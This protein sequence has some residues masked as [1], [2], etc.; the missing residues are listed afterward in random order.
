M[1][2]ALLPPLTEAERPRI[3]R[4]I[5]IV[6]GLSLGQSAFYAIVQLLDRL[7]RVEKLSAQ[8]AT[9]NQTQNAR[10]WLDVIYQLAGYFFAL[11]PVLLALYLLGRGATRLLGV[12]LRGRNTALRDLGW[13]VLLAAVI[14]IPGLGLYFLG[15]ALNLGVT[16][17]ASGLSDHWWTIPL[18]IL[19]A[20][21]NAILE[22]VIVVGYLLTRLRQLGVRPWVALLSSALLRGSYHLYQG[23]GAFVGNFVMGLVFGWYFQRR[24]RV[25]PLIV[26]HTVLDVFAF[27]GYALFGHLLS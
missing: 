14:G 24:G 20:A 11:V 21:Q 17:V 15:R 3:R 2:A 26:A 10:P 19:S 4:E 7:T 16:V 27:V 9:L 18:L 5:W 23:Y 1:T 6:L 25:M 22:E 8:T 13:G 12:D